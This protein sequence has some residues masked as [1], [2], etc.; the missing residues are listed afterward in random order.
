M[1]VLLVVIARV[2]H[3]VTVAGVRS[4]GLGAFSNVYSF[5]FN[6]LNTVKTPEAGKSFKEFLAVVAKIF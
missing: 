5:P 3:H 4:P 1:V 2:G 6:S